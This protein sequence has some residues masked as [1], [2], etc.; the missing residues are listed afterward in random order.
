[1]NLSTVTAKNITIGTSF[2]VNAGAAGGNG[3][4][5]YAVYYK[6]ASSSNW[7][8]AQKFSASQTTAIKPSSIGSYHVCVKVKDAA[9]NIAKKSFTVKV[10]KALNNISSL[11]TGTVRKGQSVTVNCA[12][13][14]GIGSYTYAVYYNKASSSVWTTGQNYSKN[15]TVTLKP[16]AKTDYEIC[17]KVKDTAGNIARKSFTVTVK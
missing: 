8:V 15:A 4:Y 10:V 13:N 11:S 17:V 12:A 2:K 7:T 3:G 9:G 5:T 14:G 1:M 16:S 6:K